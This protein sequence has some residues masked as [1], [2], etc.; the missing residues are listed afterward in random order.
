MMRHSVDVS[1]NVVRQSNRKLQIVQKLTRLET[2]LAK[3]GVSSARFV[4]KYNP[5]FSLL[6]RLA[7]TSIGSSHSSVA[8]NRDDRAQQVQS[9][10]YQAADLDENRNEDRCVGISRNASANENSSRSCDIR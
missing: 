8:A 1:A 2:E 7:R 3:S 4:Q 6:A 9:G 5:S 10:V